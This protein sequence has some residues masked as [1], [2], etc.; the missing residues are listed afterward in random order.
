MSS[1]N[2][3]HSPLSSSGA[4]AALGQATAFARTEYG[5]FATAAGV[6]GLHVADDSFFQPN[7][8]VSAA[9]HLPGGLVLLALIG[10]AVVVYPRMR[11]GLRPLTAIV[12]GYLGV[13]GG[14]EAVYYAREVGLS[15]DDY[16]GLLSIAAGLVLLGLGA[17]TLWRSRRRDDRRWWRYSRRLLFVGVT[18]LVLQTVAF[19]FTLAYVITHVARAE[20]PTA[21]LGAPYQ[22][23]EFT[24]SDGLTLRGWYIES[25][26][27]AAVISF[28][29]RAA[30]QKRA[31]M[32]ARNGY[33][34]L[35]FDRRGEGESDGDPNLFGWQGERDI[36]AAVRYLQHRPDVD[37]ERIGGIG[38][39]VG[40]EMMIEAA[41]ES[42]ALKAIVSEGGS[43]RSVRDIAANDEGRW[44]EYVGTGL[45]TAATA[46]FTSNT[47]PA[48]LKSLVAKIDPHTSVF[49]VYGERGQSVEEPANRGFYRVATGPKEIWE[50]PGS[51]HMGGIDARPAEYER[52][53][54]G[55][56]DR[57]LLGR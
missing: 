18:A 10:A 56:F 43:G 25:R 46:L 11:A 13:L 32:L 29:G 27:G 30:S 52:R 22:H 54:V 20:V 53:I 41:A 21:N 12:I 50:V 38:L 47:P 19:T 33:G 9:D 57:A 34:V 3:S 6:V 36:H 48:D 8:G 14:V 51:R 4:R 31:K 26:N 2:V 24:T 17:V 28:P 16:T 42:S 40:G 7:P 1:Q 23:V 15:G 55:F 5:V 45:A 37:P 35:L 39:S 49:F 44:Q